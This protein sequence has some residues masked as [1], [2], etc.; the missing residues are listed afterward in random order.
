L[1]QDTG[2]FKKASG[3]QKNTGGGKL[4]GLK[5]NLSGIGKK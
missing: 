5:R 2:K 3:N 4:A 1:R